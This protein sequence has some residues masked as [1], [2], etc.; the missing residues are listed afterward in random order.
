MK[1][2][3]LGKTGLEVSL[4]SFGSGGPSKLGLNTGLTLQEQDHL[5]KSVLDLGINLIDSSEMY[6][7]SETILGKSL[8]GIDRESYYLATKCAYKTRDGKIRSPE[9]IMS[10][11]DRSLNRL[12]TDYIDIMQFHVLNSNDYHRV[13]DELYPVMVQARD[14]GKIRFIGFS[15]QFW[16]ANSAV[17][18]FDQPM[19]LGVPD[20]FLYGVQE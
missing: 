15:E 1:Y 3:R 11:I 6:G 19:G 20:R 12:S 5:I 8:S 14:K 13:V 9:E 18:S 4:V 7:D 2:R 16:A 17:L 10:S